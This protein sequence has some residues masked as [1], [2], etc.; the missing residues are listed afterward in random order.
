METAFFIFVIFLVSI[1]IWEYFSGKILDIAF[2][3]ILAR[4]Q[5]AQGKFLKLIS[6]QLIVWIFLL[7]LMFFT[8]GI[9]F[10][11]RSVDTQR[12]RMYIVLIF[13]LIVFPCATIRKQFASWVK[14]TAMNGKRNT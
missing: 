6:T 5:E 1:S 10:K 4:R 13:V 2:M 14:R 7:A 8:F 9:I 11:A 12:V 3:R